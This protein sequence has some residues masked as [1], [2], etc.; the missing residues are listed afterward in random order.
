VPDPSPSPELPR[1]PASAPLAQPAEAAGEP[2][3]PLRL[4]VTRGRLGMELFEPVE[5]GPLSVDQLSIS[6]RSLSFPVDLSGGVP[7]FRSRRGQLEH[8]SFSLE[9][10]RLRLWLSS[11]LGPALPRLTRPIDV[12]WVKGGIQIGLVEDERVLTFVLHWV[13]E[14]D[15]AR[16]VVSDARGL[17]G[18]GP[19]LQQTLVLL[20]TALAPPF[21]REGRLVHLDQVAQRLARTLLPAVGA[22]APATG[23]VVFGPLSVEERGEIA[24]D[25]AFSPVEPAEAGLSALLLSRV[26][27]AADDALAASRLEQ[28]R[29]EYLLALERAPRHPELVKLVA[30]LDLAVGERLEAALGT[31]TEAMPLFAAGVVGAELLEA[32]GERAA[33]REAFL[34][35]AIGESY[36]PL[37]S[38]YCLRAA[39][40]DDEASTRGKLLDQAVARA[41]SMTAIRWLRCEERAR[42]GDLEGVRGDARHLEAQAT[43]QRDRA[44]VNRRVG[45]LLAQ[46][47]CLREA[48]LFHQRALRYDPSDTVA[49]VGLARAL[50]R[51]G[52]ARRALVPLVRALRLREERGEPTGELRLLSAQ[53]K[54]HELGELPLAIAELRE[55]GAGD[56]H[57]VEARCEEA[58]ARL[59]LGDIL[60]ASSTWKVMRELIELHHA[61][62]GGAAALREAARFERDVLRDL[63]EAERHL[64]VALRLAPLDEE[65]RAEYRSVSLSLVAKQSR[66][67]GRIEAPGEPRSAVAQLDRGHEAGNPEG[68]DRPEPSE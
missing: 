40:L 37:A 27:R 12:F 11:R 58:R 45:E 67:S 21:V 20:D 28:A 53:L 56:P 4:T 54:A 15:R 10:E 68:P 55:I 14:G 34:A 13:P 30:G 23:G 35:L 25:A 61:W 24:L 43:S 62:D 22:R 5:L 3:A 42:R 16:L 32:L 51:A 57:C 31:V 8:V 38:L 19:P 9:L 46:A 36:P 48:G 44:S 18:S 50:G 47:G 7:A 39:R 49:L 26:A 65:L 29:E 6:F 63:V 2:P 60:G 59:A 52:Q 64:A 33:A 17:G 1:E 41:P 66:A